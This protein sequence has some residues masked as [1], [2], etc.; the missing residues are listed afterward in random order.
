[1]PLPLKGSLGSNLEI[2]CTIEDTPFPFIVGASYTHIING[3]RKVVLDLAGYHAIESTPLGSKIT[4]RIG[5]GDITHN[6]DFEGFI[7]EIE[8][9]VSGGTITA[10]DYIGQLAQST[11]V[12]YKTKDI[13]GKD[14]YYLA[15]SAA[16]YKDVNVSGLTEG[17][18]IIATEDMDLQGLQT[19]REFIDKCF[20]FMSDI[21]VDDFHDEPSVVNWRYAIRRNNRLDFYKED[22]KNTSLGFKI[23]VSE[24]DNNLLGKGVMASISTSELVNSATYQSSLNSEIH[25]TVTDEQSVEQYGI[26]GKIYQFRTLEYDRLEELAYKTILIKKEPTLTY[27]VELSNAEHLTL[28]DYVKISAPPLEDV[29]LPVVEVRHIIRES[30]ES[31]ITLGSPEVSLSELIKSI[32]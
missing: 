18:G 8:P 26:A 14:L 29:I 6:L 1:M 5:K 10:I 3:G 7:Y 32:R 28:G 23:K 17:S 13:I 20:N 19:R 11:A 12:E 25:A 22:N 31:I 30:I 24:K 2:D 9:R 27:R 21:V 15:A 4:L 16:N